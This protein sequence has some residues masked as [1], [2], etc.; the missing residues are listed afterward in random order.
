M[1]FWVLSGVAGFLI[2]VA[3]YD[4]FQRKHTILRN[5][6][7]IGH[8]R[9]ILE[10]VGPELRQYIVTDNNSERPFS[11]HERRWVYASAKEQ[12]NYFGFGTDDTIDQLP[13]YLVIKHSS[14]PFTEEEPSSDDISS[15]ECG[16]V[17]GAARGRTHAFRPS[18]T[19][20]ISAMSFGSLSAAAVEAL[21]KG[22][23]MVGC[24]HNTGEG[25]I[26]PYHDFGGDLIWQI[27][28]G[29]FGCR[30]ERGR[31]NLDMLVE[32]A[33]R[34]PV[35]ALEI[36]L[37]QGAKPGH[38]GLLPGEKVT[39]EI[40]ETRGIPVGEDCVSPASHSA[41]SSADELLDFVEMVA[42]ATGLPVGIKSAVGDMRVWDDLASLMEGGQ[43]GVDF[44]TIDGGEGG[45]GAAPL[46]FADHVSYPFKTGF[47]QVY[48][49]FAERELTDDI[50]FCGSGKLGFPQS[51]LFAYA[52]GC[53]MVA[54]AREAMLSIGCI[55]A[56][57]CHTG[58]CP[59]GVATQNKWLMHG[60]DPT[61]KSARFANYLATLQSEIMGLTHACGLPHPSLVTLDHFDVL[62]ENFSSHS[63]RDLF[64]YD[65]GWGLP[66]QD[67]QDRIW[68]KARG[69]GVIEQSAA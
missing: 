17:W 69:A 66:P 63:A 34:Y 24:L 16:K 33:D 46:A 4:F 45:T 7:I 27:G 15:I 53:D 43:R 21:N 51:A 57:R 40:A 14:F 39:P 48:R 56:K 5:F 64:D 20:S 62:D 25:S 35:R 10:S 32:R 12:N 36:K 61:L 50:V 19:V 2:L 28:T 9:Y 22:A 65:Q 54:V 52:M 60:L 13:N 44:I 47:P 58:H 1:G 67:E 31:F 3:L 18:T 37:S 26:S 68:R 49:R 8:M 11:R 6:P 42:D 23:A 41:F 29:Y 59:A 30:D 55:Q 38:G